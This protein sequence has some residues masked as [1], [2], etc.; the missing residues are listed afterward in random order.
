MKKQPSSYLSLSAAS[1]LLGVH[2]T[3]LRRWADTG[4]VP[5]YVTPG[6]HR[7]FALADIEALAERSLNSEAA[8]VMH[9]PQSFQ[10]AQARNWVRR[11]LEQARSE[12][13]QVDHL[14]AWLVKFDEEDRAEWRHVSMRLMGVVLRFV[15][16]QDDD[17]ALLNEARLI[18]LDYARSAQLV[19]MSLTNAL[20]AAIFF[21]DSLIEAAMALPHSS[22]VYPENTSHLRR[23]IGRVLNAVQIAVAEGYEIAKN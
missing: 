3:T 18:G 23:R 20:E 22:P 2:C 8:L 15:S 5:V 16:M 17:V 13:E 14:P 7:R 6:G 11:A 4:A 1:Q 10:H 19:G 12:L 21:R 9:N